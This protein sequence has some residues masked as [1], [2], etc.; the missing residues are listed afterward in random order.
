MRLVVLAVRRGPDLRDAGLVR[1]EVCI[2]Y[3]S[4]SY[5]QRDVLTVIGPHSVVCET[6]TVF[7]FV[8]GN[9]STERGRMCE[10][11]GMPHGHRPA[12]LTPWLTDG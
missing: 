1:Q 6:A 12:W 10:P 8:L 11:P 5:P 3:Q 7:P 2:I 9:H 4:P